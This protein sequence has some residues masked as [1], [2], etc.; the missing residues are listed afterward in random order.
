M[1]GIYIA[2]IAFCVILSAFFSASEMAYSSANEVRLENLSDK[3]NGSAGRAVRILEK[4][5]NLI[6]T[7]LVGNN[8]VNIAA[9]SLGSVAVI[10]LAGEA[11]AWLSTIII[12]ITVIIFGETIPKICAKK[13]A[14]RLAL[15]FSAPLRALMLL[16]FPVTWVVVKLVELLTKGMKGDSDAE[17]DAADE[18]HTI[19]ETA[20][21]EEVLDEDSSELISAAIDFPETP[22]SEV[23]TARVDLIAVDA[24]DDWDEI[25]QTVMDAPFSRIPVYEDSIDNI[26]GVLSVK[27]FLKRLL[28]EDEFDIREMLMPPVFVY[29]TMKLPA[30][31]D[32]LR[33]LQ[34]HL[35]IVTDEYGGTL[36]AVS[37]EDIMEELVGEIWD[38]KDVIEE[39]I[40][41]T[42]ENTFIIDG[43]TPL[44]DLAELMDWDEDY[45]D[46]ESET[47]GGW[48]IEV[49]D[50]FP[51]AGDTFTYEKAS[52]RI[53]EADER[54]VL[55][56][57]L[58]REP[59]E[60]E[61]E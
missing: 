28:D 32:R 27:H 34:Q 23:M 31:L 5:D 33:G 42:D 38:E 55:S 54:R 2:A 11:Y 7:I 18:L 57:E 37:L 50:E 36:G 25:R 61:E 14:N 1:I 48:C 59:A 45:F 53:L 44:S 58:S 24:D 56:I 26:I 21:S 52:V 19:I 17:T 43:D 8:L 12:T 51:S 4:Y 16:F 29:K 10:L 30:I 60:E 39:D 6:S 49:L 22:V 9:S 46:F 47:V 35:A 3:G 41:E 20:E 40:H 13:N 15:L